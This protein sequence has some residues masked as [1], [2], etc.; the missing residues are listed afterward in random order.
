[1]GSAD[2]VAA[3][4][5]GGV[6]DAVDKRFVGEL[7]AVE[8]RF[9]AQKIAFAPLVFQCVRVAWKR[10]LLACLDAEPEGV[11]VARAAACCGLSE[12]ATGVLLESCLAAGVVSLRAGRYCLDK[13]G[14]FVLHD[15]MTQV[16]LNFAHDVCYQGMFR[17]EESLLAGRPLGLA[18][19]G[20]WSTVYE[21]M[22]ALPEPAQS[23]WFAFDHFYS[24]SAFPQALQWVLQQRPER[25]L[26]IG[27]N[28]G[29][30]A[31]LCLKADPQMRVTLV[32]LPGQLVRA[33]GH[34]AAEGVAERATYHPVDL[35]DPAASLPSGHDAVWMS[36]FLSC[37]E[38]RTIDQVFRLARGA[39]RPGGVV[40]V[41]DTFWDRQRFDAAAY[42]LINTSPYFAALASGCS[43]MYRSEV[44]VEA[45]TAAGLRLADVRDGIGLCHSLLVFK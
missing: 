4:P 15:R 32:D 35:L 5:G 27:A 3:S 20:P 30:W 7:T 29:K 33:A 26:D 38:R 43:K 1:M 9:E 12:Y 19:L 2:G 10:G 6:Q 17:L 16:N 13:I 21:G 25:L 23:S 14:H 28:S 41:L 24:D 22:T 45:A 11:D 44:Y 36:Q 39:L 34:L 31:A 37:L 8:A 40:Y 42:C 18:S